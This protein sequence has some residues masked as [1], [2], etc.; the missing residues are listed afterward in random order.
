LLTFND[1]SAGS[2]EL[3]RQGLARIPS[4]TL[5]Q[6]QS[7]V[8]A[9]RSW[10]FKVK[11]KSKYDILEADNSKG[12]PSD[13]TNVNVPLTSAVV[14]NNYGKYSPHSGGASH[15]HSNRRK[16]RRHDVSS[17]PMDDLDCTYDELFQRELVDMPLRLELSAQ[18][19]DLIQCMARAESAPS[20]SYTS[21]LNSRSQDEVQV[22]RQLRKRLVLK[23]APSGEMVSSGTT[24]LTATEDAEFESP[25]LSLQD[26]VHRFQ[27]WARDEWNLCEELPGTTNHRLNAIAAKAS[28]LYAEKHFQ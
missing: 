7:A 16:S 17:T 18:S 8:L 26:K 22:K 5:E 2:G 21:G 4:F 25:M 20:L 23:S 15:S 10:N 9:A 28:M 12:I 13:S 14:V 27:C 19:S 6:K 24:N 11:R 3:K 1:S